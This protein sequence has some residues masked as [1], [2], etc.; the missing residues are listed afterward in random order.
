MAILPEDSVKRT[1]DSVK[2]ATPD[3]Q[4]KT[5]TMD[6]L[7]NSIIK[8]GLARGNK[9]R[10]TMTNLSQVVEPR[11]I[12]KEDLNDLDRRISF[13]AEGFEF[14][15]KQFNL[16]DAR[17]RKMPHSAV[18][19]NINMTLKLG[20]DGLE[21]RVMDAWM[22][23]IIDKYS[24]YVKYQEKYTTDILVELLHP[25]TSKVVHAIK[26]VDAFPAIMGNTALNYTAIGADYMLVSVTFAFRFWDVIIDSENSVPRVVTDSLPRGA[27]PVNFAIDLKSVTTKITGIL[28]TTKGL[29]GLNQGETLNLYN[30]VNDFFTENTGL[31][32]N[33]AKRWT[34]QTKR[35][36]EAITDENVLDNA[37]KAV[38]VGGLAAIL[39][40]LPRP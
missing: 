9:F 4:K 8:Y 2:R 12:K 5:Q 19:D 24:D 3:S 13:M 35:D 25:Q 27:D 26:L 21:R 17:F 18:Y 22:A 11:Y 40:A 30:K 10:V 28:D 6:D 36:I 20:A 15:T 34:E 23:N 38:L 14:P 1:V 7:Q 29:L 37:N 32:I 39:A 31:S 16:T 33:D